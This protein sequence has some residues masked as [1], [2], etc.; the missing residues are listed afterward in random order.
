MRMNGFFVRPFYRSLSDLG[1][2]LVLVFKVPLT[3][4]K[5]KA[6]KKSRSFLS[7]WDTTNQD[8]R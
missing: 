3:Q 6:I 5:K 7:L 2:Y 1:F 4:N 8:R